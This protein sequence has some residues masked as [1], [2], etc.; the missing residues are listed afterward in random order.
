MLASS[1]PGLIRLGTEMHSAEYEI[2]QRERAPYPSE[3]M[4][5]PYVGAE[6]WPLL[7]APHVSPATGRA[8]S[9]KG[10]SWI[11]STG[12]ACVRGPGI[13]IERVT[14]RPRPATAPGRR[15]APAAFAVMRHLATTSDPLTQVALA[16]FAGVT[17]ARVSQA[18]GDLVGQGLIERTPL[19][20][21]APDRRA[22]LV[23]LGDHYPGPG[24]LE[25]GWYG[26]DSPSE[27]VAA[28]ASA[29]GGRCAVSG[30]VAADA[31]A[32]WRVPTLGL[33][34]TDAGVDP[35]RAGLVAT[36]VIEVATLIQCI[37]ADWSVFARNHCT[38]EVAGVA[39]EVAHPT[40]VVVDLLT[41][42]GEDRAAAAERVLRKAV[43]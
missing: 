36:E 25:I 17:Q 43:G 39:V 19:G 12:Q 8:L 26:L 10:W 18:L 5:L 32:P 31:M 1:G 15:L 23:H 34:Y 40:Q 38:V 3:A 29:G 33:V 6:P 24:G 28:V 42:G 16:E 30:D 9:A 21:R 13:L 20:W 14:V 41:Q 2:F 35:A 11:D 22:L 27:Q 4:R 37:P 7:V